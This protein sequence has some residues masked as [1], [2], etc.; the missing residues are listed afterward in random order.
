MATTILNLNNNTPAAPAGSVNVTWQ[1][2]SSNPVNVS[3]YVANISSLW[4]NL[5][6]ATNNLILSNAN[7]ATTFNQI[8]S[9]I[10]TWAN[11]TAAT[12][13]TTQQSSPVLGL[14][15]TYWTGSVS[16]VDS[17]TIQNVLTTNTPTDSASWSQLTFVH[18]GAPG[19][20]QVLLPPGSIANPGISFNNDPSTGLYNLGSGQMVVSASGIRCLTVSENTVEVT[21]NTLSFSAGEGVAVQAV[22]PDSQA[23][24][25][26]NTGSLSAGNMKSIGLT[27][28]SSDL[29]VGSFSSAQAGRMYFNTTTGLVRVYDG[30][31]LNSLAPVRIKSNLTGQ[32]A[33]IS[34]TTLFAIPA[35]QGGMYRITWEAS[36]TTADGVSSSLGGSTGFQ[37]RFTNVTDS[38][39]K[40]SN[41]TTA[42]ISAANTTGTSI[43]GVVNAYAKAGTNLQYLFG[44]TSNTPG[45]MIFDLNIYAE[46]MG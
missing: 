22:D 42:N 2:D 39:V 35:S 9:V 23:A 7:F 30:A 45:Q 3:A 18:S 27:Q 40:T 17:W 25:S 10:W 28:N 19:A 46:Y 44:Y 20:A 16:A 31:E 15:G 24:I 8:S 4:S 34:A 5:G 21:V 11:T 14:A 37:V 1:F 38:V 41:P 26:F 32:S 43:S 29:T 33:A 12:G 6:N 36:I 13:Y